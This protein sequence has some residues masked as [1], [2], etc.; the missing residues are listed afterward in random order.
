MHVAC[1]NRDCSLAS[2]AWVKPYHFPRKNLHVEI[3][4][5]QLT[6]GADPERK[7]SPAF[8]YDQRKVTSC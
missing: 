6:C 5:S 4:K 1:G 2:H 3:A 8:A 7:D